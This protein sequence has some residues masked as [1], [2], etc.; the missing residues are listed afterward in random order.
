MNIFDNKNHLTYRTY[1][2]YQN[3]FSQVKKVW[4]NIVEAA[5]TL[6]F[7]SCHTFFSLFSS[8]GWFIKLE[9]VKLK[10]HNNVCGAEAVVSFQSLGEAKIY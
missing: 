3:L 2:N 10:C 6:L 5:K 8:L 4:N 7:K 9:L 1:S